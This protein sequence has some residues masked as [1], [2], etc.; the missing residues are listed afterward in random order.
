[1]TDVSKTLEAI[2]AEL[3]D[4]LTHEDISTAETVEMTLEQFVEYCKSEIA[5]AKADEDPAPRIAA[6]QKAVELA[7]MENWEDGATASIPVFGGELSVQ[8]QSAHSEMSEQS[9][10]V[11]GPQASPSGAA[12]EAASGPTAAAGTPALR[13]MPPA[14]PTSPAA[15]AQGFMAKARDVLGKS[16]EGQSLLAEFSAMLDAEPAQPG[17]A[18]AGAP[19]EVV[20]HGWPR[21]MSTSTFL[22]GSK[23]VASE[24]DFGA[25]P[26]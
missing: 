26:R 7:K 16:A 13:A 11:P 22:E 5:K 18:E 15:G 17:D 6:L 3:S 14:F 9:V 8:A 1:M 10:S 2:G 23:P 20:D 24:D 12:F 4:L 21:D 25:D 19:A